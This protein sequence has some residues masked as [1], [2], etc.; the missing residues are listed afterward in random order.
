MRLRI[1]SGR[2][3]PPLV[4]CQLVMAEI[5]EV[6]ILEDFEA[7]AVATVHPSND[8]RHQPSPQGNP[9]IAIGFM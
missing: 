4:A 3:I 2:S 9:R 1:S 8:N 6:E 5:R 7:G